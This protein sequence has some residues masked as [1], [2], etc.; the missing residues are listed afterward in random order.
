M[1]KSKP[2]VP[3]DYA[4]IIMLLATVIVSGIL[5]L[6]FEVSL[7]NRQVVSNCTVLERRIEC[8]HDAIWKVSITNRT[9]TWVSDIVSETYIKKM[10][11]VTVLDLYKIGETYSCY[12]DKASLDIR[13]SLPYRIFSYICLTSCSLLYFKLLYP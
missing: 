10:N 6:K 12:Y 11:A 2:Q 8:C 7:K 3:I 9:D 4:P 13:W 1:D 5:A